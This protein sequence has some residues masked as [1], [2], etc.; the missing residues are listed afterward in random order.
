MWQAALPGAPRPR[1]LLGI[2]AWLSL[3]Q[4]LALDD[5]R[6]CERVV[7]VLDEEVVSLRQEEVVPC[8]DVYQYTMAGWRLDPDQTRRVSGPGGSLCYIYKPEDTRPLAWN[9]TVRTCCEGWSGPHCSEAGDGFAPLREGGIPA[10]RGEESMGP[11]FSAWQ[12]QDVPGLQ[13]RSL[14][15]MAECCGLLWGHSWRNASSGLCLSC[16]QQPLRGA[17][18]SL[19]SLEIL[20]EQA[21]DWTIS[22]GPPTLAFCS[23]TP[24]AGTIL[25][26]SQKVQSLAL[27]SCRV[28][29]GKA[30]SLSGALGRRNVRTA[31]YVRSAGRL[32]GSRGRRGF[33]APAQAPSLPGARKR[34]PGAAPL[35]AAFSLDGPPGPPLLRRPA[36]SALL[37]RQRHHRPPFATCLTWAGLHYRTFDGRHFRFG[38]NCTYALA[39]ASDGTWAVYVSSSGSG[40]CLPGR[41]QRERR[42]EERERVGG[43]QRDAPAWVGCAGERGGP[44]PHLTALLARQ[45]LRMLFGLDLVAARGHNVS[46]NGAPVPER[47]PLLRK[48]ISIWWLGDFL[49][50]ESGLGVRVKFDGH[51]TVYVTVGTALQGTTRGLCGVYS[52]DP[53]DDF[54]RVG[55]D[56]VTLA[57]SFGNSWRIPEAGLSPCTDAAEEPH[58]CNAVQDPAVQEAATA[59]CQKL[60]SRPFSECHIQVDP[61]S[62]YDT[63]R[64][65]LC[66]RRAGPGDACETFASYARECAQR[67]IFLNWRS[68]GFCEKPCGRGQ[69]YTDCVS[70]CP[71]SCTAVGMAAGDHCRQ[72]CVSGCECA[73][74]LYLE[75]GS[76]IPESRCPCFHRRQKFRPGE[77]LRQRCNQ[78]TCRGGQWVCSRD[79]CAGECV[80]H[81]HLHYLTFDGKRYSFHGACQYILVQDFV[82]G[83]IQIGAENEP[84]GNQGAVGCL[85][86]VTVTVQRTSAR[87]SFTG[88]V[89]V[90]GQEVALPFAN[91]DLMVRRASSSFLLLQA[92]GAHLLWGLEFL[93]TY[94]T[95]QPRFAHKVRGLCG[96][97]N[98][99]Q[100]EEFTTPEGD[101]EP[102]VAAFAHKFQLSHACPAT[103]GFLFDSCSTYTQRR[104]YA[105]T[106][107]A[108]IHGAP[109]Q[110]CH[111]RVEWEPFYQL[112][113]EDVCSCSAEEDCLCGALAAY[114][115]QCAQEGA[116]VSWRNRSF[117]PVQCSGGQ[118]YQECATPCGRTCADLPV[119]KFGAC[120]DL[121]TVCVAGCNCPEELV[122]D[123]EGQCVQPAMCP[124]VHQEEAHPPGSKIQKSCN[125]C[126]CVNGAWNCTEESCPRVVLCPG[127]LVHAFSSCL[128]TCESL[129][130]NLSCAGPSDGCACPPGTV[131]L[132]EHCVS[133]EECPCHHN[134]RLYQPNE[135]IAKDC[136]TCICRKQ[137]W[138][139]SHHHCA[140]T[141]VATGDPHYVTFD[142]RAYTF[143]GDCEYILVRENSGAFTVTAEN[144]PCGTSGTTCTK[145]VVVLVGSMTVHLLRGKGVTVNGVSVRPPKTYGGNSLALERAGL[146]LVLLARLGVTVLW[147][148]GT[149]V[150]I[151]LD[152]RYQGRVAGLCGNFDGDAENDFS[153]QQGI[154]EPTADLFGNSW[155]IS[156]LCP[157][158]NGEDFEHPCTVNSHRAMW[159]RKRCGVLLQDLFAACREE[160]PCQ[161]FYDWC[162]FDA[163]GCDS[164][165]D[166]ECLCTAI[167]TYAEECG[168]RGVSVRWRSQEL[169]PL[170]CDHG[171]EYDPCGPACP[172]TC[173]NFGLE[174]A[175]HCPVEA[176]SCVEGC[177]CPEG[178]V[179]H[180]GRCIDPAE[181][182]CF[183]EGTSFPLGALVM[184]ECRNCS[185]EAGLWQCTAPLEPCRALSHCTETEFAC[186]TGG[187][188]V[189]RAWLC[190]N[191]DD[192][193]DGSDELCPLS[194]T[195]HQYRCFSGQCIPWGYRCDGTIDCAD[196]SD[197]KDCPSPACSPQEFRCA[198]G[199]C[200][201][202][203]DRCDGE[204]DCGFADPSDEAGCGPACGS[205]EFRCAAGH[206]LPYL[207][208]CDG[209]D[210]CGDFSDERGCGCPLGD[211]QCP[212]GRCLPKALVCDGRQ[213][214]PSG[215]DEALCPGPVMC[216]PGQLPCP[217]ATC[218]SRA[219]VCDGVPDCEDGADEEPAQCQGIRTTP[220]GPTVQPSFPGTHQ[221][222]TNRTLV[223]LCGRYEFH[224]Q[225]GE[226]QP[227]GWVC[228]N[229]A[230]CL[231]GSD[232]LHCNRTCELDQ[233]P[234]AHGAECIHYQQLCDGIP[235][236]QDQSDESID[237]CGSTQIPPCP[238]F[239][240]CNNRMCINVSRVCDG[241][242]DCS[243]GE[244]ELA[245]E[246]PVAPPGGRNQ[247]VGPCP[248]YS[249]GDGTCIAFKQ[250][251]N[252]LAN[253]ADG[254]EASGW[255]PSDERDCGLWSP[256]P[257][258]STCSRSCGT[259][260]QVRRRSCT[261][262]ADD[263]LRHCLGEETQ[264]QQCFLVAC[265]VDGQWREWATWS[266][267]TE[268]CRGVVVRHRE[269]LP[270]Q[271]GGRHCTEGP[272]G[273]AGSIEIQLCQRED[274]LNASTCPGELVSQKCAPCPTSCTELSSRT[275]CRKDRPCRPGCWCPEGLVLNSEQQCVRPRECP[276]Q[277][278]GI[279]Y[280]PGQLVK[281][282][283]RICTCQEGQMK[284]CRQNPEC[285]VN[286][287][288][289][290]WSP[291][292]ECLGPCGVQSIQWSFRSPNNPTKHG[293][294]RQCRGIYRKARRC[295]TEPCEECEHHGRTHA[296]GDRWRSGQCQVCQC[297]PNLTVQ[298]SQYCP[299]STVGCPEGRV[300]V[301]GRADSC[302]YCLE[303]GE[304]RTA[305]PSALPL[306]PQGTTRVGS[307]AFPTTPPLSTFPLPPLGD[308]CY[309]P[310]GIASLPDA[311]F[312]ASSQQPENPAHAARLSHL[313]TGAD[314]QGWAPPAEVYP[315]LLSRPP[316]L[317]VDLGE[318]RNLTGVVIQGAGT[319]DAYVTSF[320]LQFSLDGVRWHDYQEVSSRSI[321]PELKL[322][323][324]NSDD[325]TPVARTFQRMVHAQHVRLLPHDFHNGIFLRM[326]LLGCG[327][328]SPDQPGWP[329]SPTGW[330]PCWA[331]EFRCQNGRCVPAG[332]HGAICNGVDDCGDFSDEL[333]CGI[334]PSLEPPSPEGCPASQFHCA[335][336][337]I[338]LEASERC[339]GVIHCPDATDEIGC[340]PA[341]SVPL[342]GILSPWTSEG[343]SQVSAPQPTAASP[344]SRPFPEGY[345]PTP[346]GSCNDPLGLEDGRVHYQQLTAS[347][348]QEGNPPG[349][350]RLNVAPTIQNVEPGWSPRLSDRNPY[351]QVDLLQPFFITSV[352]TQG[353]GRSRGYVSRYRLVHSSDGLHFWN[354]TRPGYGPATSL[355]AQVLEGNSDSSSPARQ[356][357]SPA[358]L[359]RFLR[360][361]PMEYQQRISLRLELFGCP[362]K[363]ER[364]MGRLTSAGSSRAPG[365]IRTQPTA[366]PS[367]PEKPTGT[368]GWLPPLTRPEAA[369]VS[370]PST[371]GPLGAT[372]SL[373]F[374][375]TAIPAAL[376]PGIAWS[377]SRPLATPGQSGASGL[378]TFDILPHRPGTP[379]LSSHLSG[380]T[381]IPSPGM[382]RILCTQGQFACEAFGCVE[383]AFVC[384]GQQDCSDGS[385]EVRCGGP[386]APTI[387]T[388]APLIPVGPPSACSSKQFSCNSGE[389]LTL[390]R[391]CDLRYDCQ[392]GSD[393]ASC[394]D[395]ILSPWS[396]WSECSRSCG[397]GVTF[398]RRD[399]LRNALPGGRCDRDEFDS[400]SCFL[401]ACPVNGAWASWGEW[402][403]CDAECRGGVRSRTRT[404]ADPP[405]KNGGQ[406]CPGDAVQMEAC[407]QQPC[408]DARDCGP[409]MVFVQAGHCA[410]G[411]VDPCP[412][413]CRQL[414]IKR[415]CQSSCVEGCRCPPGL[416]L[417]EGGCVNVSQC[418]CFFD[419]EQHRPG[420]IFLRDNCSQCVCL[421][422]TVTC[423]SVACP[424]KCGWSAWSP[425]TPCSRS[426]GVGMQQRF[427]SPSNPAAA[428]GG[429]PC[430]GDAQEVREC[431]TACT[432]EIA[433]LWSEW[434]PWS[435]CSKTCFYAPDLVG[436]RKR[437]RHCNGTAQAV[438][439]DGET[440]QEEACDTPLCP[441]EGIWTPWTAWSKCSVPCDSGV[442]TRNRTCSRPAYGGP[443]CTGP[444]IQTRDCNTQPC[445]VQCP[446]N[447]VYLT[448]EECQRKG[449]ACPRLCLDQGTQVECASHCQEGCHCP[450]G[451][452]LQNGSCV[453]LSQ[454]PCYYQGELYQQ[455]S[456]IP[457]DACN[458]CT[459][460]D[461][462][463][464]CGTEPCSADC[465]WS[466]WTAWSACSRTC[467]VG[468][469]RRYRSSSEPSVSAGGQQC[470]GSNVE[471]EFCSLQ[472]CQGSG[473]E[474]GPWS[475]CSVPCG[476][477]YQNRTRAS[478]SVLGRIDFATCNLQPCTGDVPGICPEGKVWQECAD[479]PASC[480]ELSMEGDPGNTA[481]QP[482]CYCPNGTILL[483]NLCVPEEECPCAVEGMLYAPGDAVAKGCKNCSCIAGQVGNCSR[484][485]CGDVNGQWSAWTPWSE[486]SASCG[487]G[488]QNR[489]HFCT[490][491]APSGM[492]L[493]CLGPEREDKACQIQPCSRN[494]G[495]GAWGPWTACTFSC[496]G[497]MRSR[498]RAC[499]S[500]APR[501]GG[502]YCEGPPTQVDA[503]SLNPCPALDCSAL[504]DSAYSSCGPPCPRSCDDITHCMW[505]CEPGCYCTGGKV[506]H[507]NGSTCVGKQSCTCLDL[508]TGR[509]HLPGEVLPH[510]DGCNNCTCS[511]GRL[512]CTNQACAVPGSWC[513]WAPWSPCSRTCGSEMVTRYRTCS[514][515]KPQ[516]GGH[517]CEG[518]QE[519]HGDSGVQLQ[520]KACLI[521]TFCPV[522]GGW[523]TWSTWSP[524]NS[525][526]GVSARS[527][528]C[529]NPPARFGGT[530]CSGEAR[531]SRLCHDGATACEDCEGGQVAFPCSK[532]CPRTCE[533]QQPD[534]AC[535]ESPGCQLACACPDGQLL[536][537]GV[538][539]APSQCRCKYQAPW[540]GAPEERNLSSWLGLP[541]WEYAQPGET[542]HGP[543]QNCTCVAGHL[544]C[545]A[546]P[547]CRLD[548]G[549]AGWGPWSPCSQSCGEGVQFHFRECSN[550]APQNGGRGCVG[551]SEQQRP[552]GN[553]EDCPEEDAWDAW[554]PWAPCSVSCG[555]GEQVRSRRCR[556]PGC[557]GL[558]SQSKTCNTHVCLEVGC[559]VGRLYR[560]C[561]AEE[562]CPYSCA[563]LT[564]QMDCFSDGCEEGCHCP[565]GTYQ[566]KGACIQECP[567]V[568]S[569]EVFQ[570]LRGLSAGPPDT[571]LV[572]LTA[573][574]Q[575]V[576]PGEEVAPNSTVS[577]ACSNCS[578]RNGQLACTFTLCPVDG[579]FTAWSPWSPCSLTCGGLGNMT[580]SRDCARP[581]PAH[582]GK[583]CA[584]P[585][586]DIKFCQTLD[587]KEMT[588]ATKG[589]VTGTPGAE[590]NGFTRWSPWTPCSK[591]CSDPELPALK[592]RM[593]FC[594]GGSGCAGDTFQERE[595][596]LPQ[597]T[598]TPLCEGKEC[599]GLN[600]T[601]NP[602]SLWSECSR[603]CG[604][605][606][607]Q[608]LRTYHPPGQG[609]HWCQDILTANLERRFCN[610]QACKVDGAWSK[611]SPW[612]WCDRTCGGGRS[613]RTRTCTSPP[614]KNGGRH[615]PGEKYHVRVCNP[616]PCEETCPPLM[617][618]VGCANRC[619]RHC[620]DLQ[621]GIV[622]Q[623]KEACEP[624]C[625]CPDDTLE[626]DGTCVALTHCECTDAQ[627]H[628]WAPG[629]HYDDGCNTCTCAAGG[630]LLCT[631]YTCLPPEC[632]WSLWSSWS[633]CSLT[634]GNGL[635]TRFRTP[636]SGSWAP[637]CLKEQVQTRPC[638]LDPCPPL[639]LH[640]GQETSLGSTWLLGEC[641]QCICTPE[642]IYCLDIACAVHGEW[643]P[644]S[645]WSDCLVTC[646]GSIQIRTRAC[647]NPPPRNQGLPCAGPETQ[648]QNCSTQPC[649]EGELCPW[650]AWG[651][652]SQSCGTGL[653]TRSRSCICPTSESADGAPC[654]QNSHPQE[655]EACYLQACRDCPWSPW[656]PWTP[657]ACSFLV[658]QRY[659]NQQGWDADREPC[660]GLDGQFRM[661]NYSQCS[662][663][664]C[665]A[666]FEFQA[667]GSPC[668]SHCSTRKHPELCQDIPRCLPGCYCPQ[669]LLEQK[670]ACVPH[671]QCVCLHPH[672][673]EGPVFLPAGEAVLIG[674]KK[675]VCQEGELQC[676][677]E[678]CQGLLPLSGWSPW[679][680]CSDCLPVTALGPS[681]VPAL[682]AQNEAWPGGGASPPALVSVQHR[683]RLCL[684]PQTGAPWGGRES[685]CSA[686]LQEQR[687]CPD[688]TRACEDFCL[689]S[690]WGAWS[691]CRA[692]CSGGFRLRRR[693][694]L[695]PAAE[696]RCRGPRSQSENC[697]TGPC[698]GEECEDRG[699][700][701]APTC[702]NSCPRTCLDLWEHVECLQGQCRPGCQCPEGQLLQDGDCVPIQ[703]CRCGRPAANSSQ[704]ILPGQMVELDCHNCTCLNGTF[705]CPEEKCPSYGEWSVWSPCSAS[706]GGGKALRHRLCH[707]SLLGAPCA[708]EAMEEV[709]LCNSQPCP[710][711][712]LLSD[713]TAWSNCSTSC[714][715]GASERSRQLLSPPGEPCPSPLLQQRVCN[716]HNCTPECP[717]GQVY[718]ECANSCPYSC[719]G[720][721]PETQCLQE[722][723]QPGCICPPGQVLQ[724]GL[725]VPPEEC[726]CLIGQAPALPWAAN[727]SQEERVQA[728]LPGSILQHECNRCVCRRGVFTCTREDCDVP[729][730]WSEWSLWS[731]CPVTCGTGEQLS[732]RHQLQPRLYSGAECQGPAV[733]RVP[734]ALPDC[735]CP[736]GELWRRAHPPG[737]CERSCR[738][739]YQDLP[740]N[741]S[742]GA[743][744]EGCTCQPG[745]YRNGSG[746]CVV[747]AHC[748]CEEG[749]QIYS[750]SAEWRKGCEICRCLNGRAVCETGCLPLTCLEGEVK[751]QEPGSCCPTCRK[752][753][754][755]EPQPHCR[756]FTERRNISKGA[757]FLAGVEVSYCK[758]RCASHTNVIP[759]EPYLQTFCD[760]CS[761]R[762]DPVSPVRILNLQCEG[763]ETEPVVLPVIHG[764]ECSSCQSGD[765]SKR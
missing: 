226:C 521:T 751:V 424:V 377:T 723:C 47:E 57:A 111:D 618:W 426:C 538:C 563:H 220:L 126:V 174:P 483:N 227:R 110:P 445:R 531:Q 545:Q 210:D 728:H 476:G 648:S 184:Q 643:T 190:D 665:D 52:D 40:G 570:Q 329:T 702:A 280:W 300:L 456:S 509:R 737:P 353:G 256:W 668:D 652:C 239:F 439:C 473:M 44:R 19:K 477:G 568:L 346:P 69:R 21:L 583:D 84:C 128:L 140:G 175:E 582:G 361:V 506:L 714:G 567:C 542:I 149:R 581:K 432:T 754:V 167:A 459:C 544:Q 343:R 100:Q 379:G 446:G 238:G 726:R 572:I 689:W 555:G 112:C 594:L 304:N 234:C 530:A 565:A 683:Y 148:G 122:L 61:H 13:N 301:K 499:D 143:L 534:A 537:D 201:P 409:D 7:Q 748:E 600:C 341:S 659:R 313:L 74:G 41:C 230:D 640:E 658:Q 178:K 536:Q 22:K 185:C 764:C 729:C 469:Q 623:E 471:I 228:D 604:V 378:P 684:D 663:S 624:G 603:S 526:D 20:P 513:D 674:C 410:R 630:R 151:K 408:G 157:E 628:S 653:T 90:N 734:C 435:P 547:S 369:V 97:Y 367:P 95:L 311:S 419:Q 216:A 120:E 691:P 318:P 757:C 46:V 35:I 289:S 721:R 119:E 253:C 83:K 704:E 348:H 707:E 164:G 68:P 34:S 454:C 655:M 678:D 580:R 433:F 573:Q 436:V 598:E 460:V 724:D 118:V 533:D 554:T 722:E 518:L 342:P 217:N 472:P 706:C 654:S 383:A 442:Q 197:E 747:A 385:D 399:L 362:W 463:M 218:V 765:L 155:R 321:R 760:C 455:G 465:G 742:S 505:A 62:F 390:E 336:S 551:S 637:E 104:Q 685:L 290:A 493:P 145:S 698:P 632:A 400:R 606:Q 605:G 396:T 59:T 645:P 423:D 686:A 27:H 397:L 236:C 223:P 286:C 708:A 294:G 279:R 380:P 464:D 254:T 498:S 375:R 407:N 326:E 755:D 404:C 275:R 529:N 356:E 376:T 578:C 28:I 89:S 229:E 133:P 492:G 741:C 519:Y 712:C 187:R 523:S 244:D 302:C 564:R 474:W 123:H 194:C 267:C 735:D 6:W 233:F 512:I 310:L 288:W 1:E 365:I 54:Q 588:E 516:H 559:P 203:R 303:A 10:L 502:D 736:E 699:K 76:C 546:D 295:Q 745:H 327:K 105:E 593:R 18:P 636:T 152:A 337:G 73:P 31:A 457:R 211:F 309:G 381:L 282:N 418:H 595:C 277:V 284:R 58:S 373:Q 163:C 205:S 85:R 412:Q 287:G 247:T 30:R 733:R 501:G 257:P 556:Q 231:D 193:R 393:E 142:G 480:A 485:A 138:E 651:P 644:W 315:E 759:E 86:A 333:R 107:C 248:E 25:P 144:V 24:A 340:V 620:W 607:Q 491:P 427:R 452:F 98:W 575:Q 614:P 129:Q 56:V 79:P 384:D 402:S 66:S 669:G 219:Q 132:N 591:T 87:L 540:P 552:C 458:N 449:G 406:M 411:L 168:R 263:V 612:S 366:A 200:I 649:S 626:Q 213:D 208:H 136:N 413:T 527:R 761:Y 60:F 453:Q 319:S 428:N 51:S 360:L 438:G 354:Y 535:L 710:A 478:A 657:C 75:E 718:S 667:C 370:Q 206:C 359:A 746:H 451:L 207:H 182:P 137:R 106:A 251:C 273:S 621:E 543:C 466:A 579:G 486:C 103:G 308:R 94:I 522:N 574:G 285:T 615:C 296:I 560:E 731:P 625:R 694:A 515:P 252:G 49:F 109:F 232:E 387:P 235:H 450:D 32:P 16:S 590:D 558:A 577:A 585:R 339:D 431:H 639:C 23:E 752:E 283:C 38:G 372:P 416:F 268:D 8:L 183:W 72:E 159:A 5:G 756:H 430:Q 642:G 687:L 611:W 3:W 78:C 99:N 271:N 160:L 553:Q 37:A 641:Q 222:V 199:R 50:V 395:C 214:C 165:G 421:D 224:C 63:C 405:P 344:G 82:D 331:G 221:P 93:A 55:G 108:A 141:C 500:P 127:E 347:S 196:R 297:L 299:Y 584:G 305:V 437:F 482:G 548:G 610:L 180:G 131:F 504:E 9:R 312:T 242:P 177:F 677:S 695:H 713:W 351:F 181:C 14:F 596:N 357:L 4:T 703:A 587:C 189:P 601:W 425:W 328:V 514:C 716:T 67:S 43:P 561:L 364:A 727:L 12:C 487:L 264:A 173:Q 682:L 26:G 146:F 171:A 646:G 701:Y 671:A 539:V 700:V 332:P 363:A 481:C 121:H 597:C 42:L 147:D 115:R 153:S 172:Q 738:Q 188:C 270:S 616:Q 557:H 496:G 688:E 693:F 150:Y 520:R 241:S 732:R 39:A 508:R 77:T 719:S 730:V 517:E 420:E 414:G 697:N 647:I 525:C 71:A 307:A 744:Q 681:A 664:S 711:G 633:Q 763:G 441:V 631:N 125:S 48:G 368:P 507:G 541:R 169:C 662:E 36:P 705:A 258:W 401:R 717:G 528:D 586:T 638:A 246:I 758:G 291:W 116:L 692:P 743:A 272:D 673:A 576:S 549:W 566:H 443:G 488:L 139:C 324:G 622:C 91:A 156:L 170:Q 374:Q 661:C 739:I 162:V 345:S 158:V 497:G 114:A 462:E 629:S 524:C 715:G 690:E 599:L 243:Q 65:L 335:F 15:S 569:E 135:T 198:N 696:P 350:G 124:C 634:C 389:C 80:L 96:T 316:F 753:S 64:Y 17:H 403:D 417:Q 391:R 355:Q 192:C 571:P 720:L 709:T 679:T 484:A 317:Q 255:L 250:V 261:R 562:G 475:E 306:G 102:S 392:D 510:A 447:M 490:E 325:S 101:V 461:G 740:Q 274:C 2:L 166:C 670:G 314:L 511:N 494:G 88:A 81:G 398:R 260:L 479:G 592:T 278:G 113:L 245:C 276:C 602:W 154:V 209:H 266:N 130:S 191:E 749:G 29:P 269:C 762:L 666:P 179:L 429:A 656:T 503:C 440:V 660:L 589:P 322:F 448:A 92:F 202:H 388:M 237:T 672:Q 415:S 195:P 161:Q 204:L 675:C 619:P 467:N 281:V 470:Q 334:A 265:P 117:C 386:T 627:G 240:I 609:G 323:Q 358:I 468:T 489:Y 262:R 532:P 45:A 330:R 650:S 676:S 70:S 371:V 444:L 134:G 352:A 608:R 422:G 212:G 176:A 613:A 635:H 225:S 338:C 680:P 53:A 11:C 186:H 495:W 259:G 725:C 394:V 249:C 382:P 215:M 617:R 298:C 33:A 293:N 292:G 434:T 349:A 550:P 750:A 320:F